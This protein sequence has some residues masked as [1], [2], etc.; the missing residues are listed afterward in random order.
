MP[1]PPTITDLARELGVSPTTVSDALNGRGRLSDATRERVRRAALAAGYQPNAA[2]RS[3]VGGRTGLL[4]MSLG[5]STEDLLQFWNVDYFLRVM[6]AASA[7]AL[8]QGLAL[9]LAP[10]HDPALLQQIP[11]DGAIVLDPSDSH[12]L[13]TLARRLDK[14][15][16][17]IG[18]SRH[19]TRIVDNDFGTLTRQALDLMAASGSERPVLLRG[20]DEA[21]YAADIRAAY[22]AWCRSRGLRPR[23][24]AARA[25]NEVAGAAR[26]RRALAGRNR[27]DAVLATTERLALGALREVRQTGLDV[28]ADLQ[29]VG[30]GDSQLAA[31]GPVPLT[32]VEL[33]PERLG[34]TAMRL[35]AEE[36]RGPQAPPEPADPGADLIDASARVTYVP[37]RLA[38]RRSTRQRTS[39]DS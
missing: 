11:F 21:S 24:L 25:A 20:P 22:V 15:L 1:K 16:V 39:D 7:K 34:E 18:R 30:F 9:V 29:L 12:P 28:P 5:P 36:L 2:A 8:A 4:L 10:T 27:P 13:V 33:Q 35:L 19:S 37:A 23:E 3:L 17:T 38:C 32:M 31:S 14:P 6:R 26:V